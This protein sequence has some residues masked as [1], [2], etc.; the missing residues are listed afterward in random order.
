MTMLERAPHTKTASAVDIHIGANIRLLRLQLGMSQEALAEKIGVTFQ[1]VQKYEKGTNR[2]SG[3]RMQSIANVLKVEPG[4][5]FKDAPG[6]DP[7]RASTST[8]ELQLFLTSKEG[9]QLTRAFNAIAD[10][11]M[12]H[13][14]LDL[15]KAA[16]NLG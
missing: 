14:I 4:D 11:N 3:S 9:F 5:F 1:Q 2:V 16:A 10:A 6:A 8:N 13:K 7:D 12:R 15:V